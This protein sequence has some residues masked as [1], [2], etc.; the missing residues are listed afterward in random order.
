[1][2]IDTCGLIVTVWMC[3]FLVSLILIISFLNEGCNLDTFEKEQSCF[4][5]FLKNFYP[6][7]VPR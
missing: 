5:G 7:I 6:I 4:S 3:F 1:M 2:Q